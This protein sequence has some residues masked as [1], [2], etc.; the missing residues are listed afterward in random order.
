M[1]VNRQPTLHKP[2]IMA[3]VAKVMKKEK[4][5]RLHYVNCNTYNADFDGDEMNLHAPQDPIGRMEALSIAKADKQYLVP[6]S[7]KPL[8]GLIQ[9]H[10]IAGAMLSKRDSYFNRADVCFL[11]YTGLRA[12]VDTGD[13]TGDFGKAKSLNRPW[14]QGDLRSQMQRL[15]LRI[16][17]PCMLRPRKLWSG[18]QVFTMLLKNLV[19][20]RGNR[21]GPCGLHLESSSKTPGDMWNGKLDGDKEESSVLWQ[22]MELLRGVL[23]KSQFG[24]TSFGLTHIIH[25]L[26]GSNMTGLWFSS[27]ARML[28]SM[29]QMR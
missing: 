5:I 19:E 27:L 16:D 11:L 13:V 20:P 26:L 3:H 23:D 29:L 22:D 24:A 17:Q 9:D 21:K 12:A 8:R 1:L 7:G 18:K 14:V 25:E 6:T 2:G 10:C 28:T 15:R 4:T